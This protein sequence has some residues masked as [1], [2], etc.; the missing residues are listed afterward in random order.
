MCGW[1][2]GVGWGGWVVGFGEKKTNLK[3]FGLYFRPLPDNYHARTRHIL[4]EG[5]HSFF[6]NLKKLGIML[7]RIKNC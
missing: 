6:L 7:H 5:G 3:S 4:P 2:V 1:V